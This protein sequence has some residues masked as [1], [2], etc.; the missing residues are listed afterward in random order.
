[1]RDEFCPWND[2]NWLFRVDDGVG[3]ASRTD[4]PADVT[5]DIAELGAA[6][7]GGQPLARMAAAGLVQGRP[8]VVE[9]LDAAF[10]EHRLPYC[11]EGF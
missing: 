9:A 3:S 5:L 6:Y 11:P 8:E 1:M 7:L 4:A 10:L 2:G